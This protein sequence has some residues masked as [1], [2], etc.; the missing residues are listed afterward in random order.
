MREEG[1]AI[2]KDQHGIEGTEFSSP[3]SRWT[4]AVRETVR[5]G[6]LLA[7]LLSGVYLFCE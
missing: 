5:N 6:A 3:T 4:V 2:H 7:L 1:W